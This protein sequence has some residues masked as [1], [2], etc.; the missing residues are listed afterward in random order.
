[1]AAQAAIATRRTAPPQRS[2]ATGKSVELI[3]RLLRGRS[4]ENEAVTAL[5][6]ALRIGDAGD[7]VD[8]VEPAEQHS[9]GIAGVSEFSFESSDTSLIT[10]RLMR[11]SDITTG[12]KFNPTPNFLNW[13]AIV[14]ERVTG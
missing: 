1:M 6:V 13:T 11:P 4:V 9:R 12:V 10:L 8:A 2:F 3:D 5:V 14:Q 7:A